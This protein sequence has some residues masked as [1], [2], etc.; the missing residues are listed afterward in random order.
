M[1]PKLAV[2]PWVWTAHRAASKKASRKRDAFFFSL[3]LGAARAP[4]GLILG[5]ICVRLYFEDLFYVPLGVAGKKEEPQ[6]CV[7]I[8][9][10]RIRGK[11]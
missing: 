1:Q 5:E 8:F 4:L 2:R 6:I 7:K 11:M 3:L 10:D 9:E